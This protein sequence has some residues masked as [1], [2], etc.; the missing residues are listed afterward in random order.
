[1]NRAVALLSCVAVGLAA[2][3]CD[4][5]QPPAKAAPKTDSHASGGHGDHSH[6]VALGEG[7]FGPY[8]V[9]AS[10]DEGPLKPGGD[11]PIDVW[12][13]GG[14]VTAVRF[15]IGTEDGKGAMKSRAEIENASDPT[16]WHTHAEVPDPIP[17]GG[18]LW[19]EIEGEG[20]GATTASFDLKN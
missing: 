15:W 10:R 1:M 9:R 5:K 11:A 18:K 12:V 16:H 2:A 7:T 3:G 13:T 20:G 19:V 4:S 17:Q 14:P 8:T 6:P